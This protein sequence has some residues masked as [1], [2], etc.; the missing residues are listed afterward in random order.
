MSRRSLAPSAGSPACS[1]FSQSLIARDQGRDLRR[2]AAERGEFAEPVRN[3]RQHR[4]QHQHPRNQSLNMGNRAGVGH[5]VESEMSGHVLDFSRI[6]R[7]TEPVRLIRWPSGDIERVATARLGVTQP[8]L[9]ALRDDRADGA[10]EHEARNKRGA[11]DADED[12]FRSREREIENRVRR[13]DRRKADDR[14]R[15]SREHEYVTARGAVEQRKIEAQTGPKRNRRDKQRRRIDEIGN[16]SDRG[17]RP[18]KRSDGAKH[19]LRAG[20]ARERLGGDIDRRQRP[21]GLRQIEPEADRQRQHAGG[22]GFD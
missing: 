19:R 8:C 4:Q 21:I 11:G 22:E 13:A 18:K 3:R 14:G 2:N 20:R 9:D 6:G 1:G 7:E 16:Q 15:V 17:R 12:F 5:H 10:R